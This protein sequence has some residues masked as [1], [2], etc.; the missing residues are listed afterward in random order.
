MTDTDTNR[1]VFLLGKMINLRPFAKADIPIVTRWINDPEVREFVLRV[2][3]QT[4]KQ[5]DGWYEKLG[6][7]EKNVVLCI[8]TK[9][10]IPIGIMGIHKIEWV[11][12]TATTGAMI[13]EKEFWGKGFGTDAKMTLLN[14]AFNTLN[15]RKILSDV[16]VFN[17]R[18]LRYSLRCGYQIEGRRRN[19]IFKRGEYWDL[20]ELG[21]FR[22]E[23]LPIWERYQM[24]G[25]VQ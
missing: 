2:F 4:E 22:N 3:P 18:S 21:V 24:T 20:I 16:I 12:R 9:D 11:N 25:S 8:E 1:V 10:G 15:L 5:E 17:E 7:D 6:S 14:Y 13:G 23:W 19:Q